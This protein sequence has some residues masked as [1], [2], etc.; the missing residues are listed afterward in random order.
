ML[1]VG[2]IVFHEADLPEMTPDFTVSLYPI[3]PILG[4]VLS[5]GL[6]G[7][8]NQREIAL[9]GAFV[10][11][12][13]LWYFFYARNKTTQQGVLSDYIRQREQELPDQVVT[14]A[15][16]VSPAPNEGPTIMVALSN[17]RA[18]STLITLASALARQK[19]GRVLATHIVTVP[20][21]TALDT[22]AANRDRTDGSPER[23]LTAAKTDSGALDIIIETKTS[24]SHR[25]IE[26]VFG[27]ALPCVQPLTV[28]EIKSRVH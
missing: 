1:K 24:L 26:E 28:T 19:S 23:L 11:A 13:I 25:D 5:L 18:E 12:A 20:D 2:L 3:T 7:F 6:V 16:A 21:R 10:L 17:L 27:A 4:A 9:S 8:I 14:A 15:E 22:A